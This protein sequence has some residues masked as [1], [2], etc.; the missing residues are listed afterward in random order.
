M[1][2][3]EKKDKDIFCTCCQHLYLDVRKALPSLK[4]T[5]R[6]LAIHMGLGHGGVDAAKPRPSFSQNF[7][8]SLRMSM[9][10]AARVG[11]WINGSV[12]G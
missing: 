6:G 4:L 5:F 3:S 11:R 1:E 2:T 9:W 10:V 12:S 8:Y 7:I